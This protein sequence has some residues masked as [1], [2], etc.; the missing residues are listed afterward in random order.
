MQNNT[1][2]CILKLYYN[3]VLY[4]RTQYK[5]CLTAEKLGC[6]TI[7][8]LITELLTEEESQKKS[9]R[10]GEAGRGLEDGHKNVK[11]SAKKTVEISRKRLWRY[12]P[13]KSVAAGVNNGAI[14]D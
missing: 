12:Q 8:T 9:A 10:Y 7:T 2:Q 14:E 13:K 1:I 3:V 11:I 6:N 5:S 4:N